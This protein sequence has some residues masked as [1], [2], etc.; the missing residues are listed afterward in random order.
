MLDWSKIIRETKEY[1]IN[2]IKGSKVLASSLREIIEYDY[3]TNVKKL[4]YNEKDDDYCIVKSIYLDKERVIVV[5]NS[6]I[7]YLDTVS[8]LPDYII[9]LQP[10]SPIR[11]KESIINAMKLIEK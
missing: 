8:E 9:I 5:E 1:S 11:N 3:K 4:I 6:I 2:Q 7:K 10:T